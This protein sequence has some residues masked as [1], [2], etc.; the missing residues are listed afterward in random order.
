MTLPTDLYRR[1][2]AIIRLNAASYAQ[3][4]AGITQEAAS[5]Y[6]DGGD[7]WTAL[8]VVGHLHDFDKIFLMRAKRV[9]TEDNP[10]LAPQDHEQLVADA[11]YN[12]WDKG[13]LAETFIASRRELRHFFRDLDATDWTRA[14]THPERDTPFTLGDALLQV[15]GHDADHLEQ[16]TRLLTLRETGQ[17]T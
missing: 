17:P 11:A 1:L 15:V 4:L 2:N 7:G 14:G 8:E 3:L 6:R 16:V 12:T 10:L 5:T 13:A 9:L